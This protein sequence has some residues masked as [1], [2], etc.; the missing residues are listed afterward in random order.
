M[1]LD[2]PA[3]VCKSQREVSLLPLSQVVWLQAQDKYVIAHCPGKQRLLDDSLLTL[4]RRFAA[5]LLR[6]HRNALISRE[7][8]Q[9]MRRGTNN[10]WYA[11]LAESDEPPQIS[12]RCLTQ[13]RQLLEQA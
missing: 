3:L 9:G 5:Q 4:E 13:L 11:V 7:R 2:E 8:F 6:V 12:R 1:L 10:R